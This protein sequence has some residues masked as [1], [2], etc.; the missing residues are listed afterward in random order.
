M[1]LPRTR[2]EWQSGTTLVELLV[3]VAI[4]GFAVALIVG[5]FSSGLLQATIAKRNTASTTVIQYEMA[6][7]SG[8]AFNPAAQSYSDCFATEAPASAPA[9][10]SGFQGSCPDSTYTLRADV[11]LAAGPNGSQ[12]WTVTVVSWPDLSQSGPSVSLIKV[13]R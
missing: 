8:G 6:A 1:W 12:Q 4:I 11:A 10:A 9:P 2:R 7:I 3:S 13:N 5:A